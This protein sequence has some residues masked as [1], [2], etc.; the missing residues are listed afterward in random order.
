MVWPKEGLRYPAIK[1]SFVFGSVPPGWQLEVN[2][3]SVA[4]R[5][6]GAFLTMAELSSGTYHFDLRAS[7]GAAAPQLCRRT[8]EVEA[9]YGSSPK[10]LEAARVVEPSTTAVLRAGDLL[11]VRALGPPGL[12]GTFEV[13]KLEKNLPLVER[14]GVYEGYYRVRPD[15]KGKDLAVRVQLQGKKLGKLKGEAPG[16]L[17]VWDSSRYRVAVT[18]AP[19]TVVKSGAGGYSF[20]LSSGVPLAVVGQVGPL[21]HVELSSAEDGWVPAD[22]IATLPEGTPPPTGAVGRNISTK[23]DRDAS[24]VYLAVER[25]LP[26]EVRQTVD[27]LS[28]EVRFYGGQHN[29]DRIH[30]DSADP[31]VREV[32]WRQE[33]PRTAVFTVATR[34]AWGWGYDAYYDHGR[35]VLEIRRPPLLPRDKGLLAGR[36]VAIDPGHGPEASAVGPLGTTERDAALAISE[37]LKI[38]LELEGA[39]VYMVRVSSMGP[40]LQDRPVLAWQNRA[41][42]YVSVHANALPVTADPFE[43]PRGYMIFYYQPQSRALAD[44]VHGSYRR[45]FP[46]L[47]DEFVRWGDLAVCREPQMPAILVESAY[48]MLPEQEE[49]LRQPHH[50]E[51]F[52]K[53]MLDGIREYFSAY[54][55]VQLSSEAEKRAARD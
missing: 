18:S 53:A 5:A 12:S 10:D 54:R 31:V 15:D 46:E 24:R 43:A 33:G 2:G 45:S 36:R 7:S 1:R 26:F 42:L 27:P 25:A 44:A 21:L 49:L 34:V 13:Q 32:T 30:Y 14:G 20:F 3:A 29:V 17:S 28:F 23:A 6:S 51:R 52:A 39:S 16:K 35:F 50:Q 11:P 37:K 47:T 48:M 38:L 9:P 41:D 55:R 8:V 40:S 22:R 19:L 4:V